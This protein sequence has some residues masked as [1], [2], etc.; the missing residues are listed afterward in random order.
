VQLRAAH[1]TEARL[2]HV[3]RATPRAP[4][5]TGG[6]HPWR[7]T[8]TSHVSRVSSRL[9]RLTIADF[10]HSPH[11]STP[12]SRVLVAVSPTIDC[13]LNE[14]SFSAQTRIEFGQRPPHRVT[15][16]LVDQT[17]SSVL[18]LVAACAWIHAV[19]GLE[20]RAQGLNIDGFNITSDCVF[21][22]DAVAGVL[23]RDPLHTIIVLS[24]HQWSSGWDRT[25]CSIWVDATSRN[26]VRVHGWTILWVLRRTQWSS[27]RPLNLWNTMLE[28][29]PWTTCHAGGLVL[30]GMLHLVLTLRV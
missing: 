8:R 19:L 3:T 24:Y 30:R 2:A 25:W 27:R 7:T 15:F 11:S 5:S 10:G 17:I 14:S 16:G 21:H 4:H 18:F 22:L 12:Q 13:T 29:R 9:N 20:F 28:L 6:R 23:E 1:I 26:I